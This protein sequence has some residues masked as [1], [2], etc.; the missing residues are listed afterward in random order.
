MNPP[1]PRA[2]AL[3]AAVTLLPFFAAAVFALA[4]RSLAA[5]SAAWIGAAA[6]VVSIA[7]LGFD[8]F[9]GFGRMA[10]LYGGMAVAAIV[11]V[12]LGRILR[13]LSAR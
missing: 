10:A 12:I 9:L 4:G 5:R 7:Y 3:A 2:L 6:A 1:D 8:R 11:G 13:S